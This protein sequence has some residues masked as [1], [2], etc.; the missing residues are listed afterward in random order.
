MIDSN[1]IDQ[2]LLWENCRAIGIPWKATA[3]R[4]IQNNKEGMIEDPCLA[5]GQIRRCARFVQQSIDIKPHYVRFPLD[6][7]SMEIVGELLAV[8]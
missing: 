3:D 5:H 8:E 6:R 4:H 7:K 2:H 1:I